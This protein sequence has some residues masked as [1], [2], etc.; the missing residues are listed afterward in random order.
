MSDKKSTADSDAEI[1]DANACMAIGAGVGAVGVGGAVLLGAVCPICYVAAPGL[2]ALGAWKRR[3]VK[4]ASAESETKR[5][6]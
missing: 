4:K 2:I 5:E 1:R 6:K 3:Q